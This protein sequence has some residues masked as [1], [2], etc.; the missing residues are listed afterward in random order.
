VF[1]STSFLS[2]Q[3]S[4]CP[5]LRFFYKDPLK[6]DVDFDRQPFLLQLHHTCVD[7]RLVC[8]STAVTFMLHGCDGSFRPTNAHHVTE[9]PAFDRTLLA[10]VT[11]LFFD[12]LHRSFAVNGTDAPTLLGVSVDIFPL[13]YSTRCR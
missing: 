9:F 5:R 8:T 11:G 10:P 12:V 13:T 4:L 2:P 3:S 7:S 1:H 6:T